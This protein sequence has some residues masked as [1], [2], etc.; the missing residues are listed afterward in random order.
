MG[1][2]TLALTGRVGAPRYAGVWAM[3]CGLHEVEGVDIDLAAGAGTPTLIQYGESDVI[4]SPGRDPRRR[5]APFGR[6]L[7]RHPRR[8]TTWRIVSGS[9]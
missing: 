7:A 8:P 3:C 1:F 4:I 2:L 6:R 9:R 5:Q